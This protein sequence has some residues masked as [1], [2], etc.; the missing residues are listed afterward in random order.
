MTLAKIMKCTKYFENKQLEKIDY[1]FHNKH[2]GQLII[3]SISGIKKISD[4]KYKNIL[5]LKID[6]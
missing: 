4:L 2:L 1:Y 6:I 3:N 5:A